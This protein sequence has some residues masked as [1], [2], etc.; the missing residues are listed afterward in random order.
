[1]RIRIPSQPFCA[2]VEMPP[3]GAYTHERLQQF[4]TLAAEVARARLANDGWMPVGQLACEYRGVARNGEEYDLNEIPTRR[5]TIVFHWHASVG[6]RCEQASVRVRCDHASDRGVPFP[7]GWH[8]A[9]RCA[10]LQAIA[11]EAAKAAREELGG[12]IDCKILG[13]CRRAALPEPGEHKPGAA[14]ILAGDGS[15]M[16]HLLCAQIDGGTWLCHRGSF[17]GDALSA[18][19]PLDATDLVAT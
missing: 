9:L 5:S 16:A 2:H 19:N 15:R 6:G 3:K 13:V 11:D 18:W 7:D 10:N 1:M 14:V 12:D 17:Q 8:T 4:G